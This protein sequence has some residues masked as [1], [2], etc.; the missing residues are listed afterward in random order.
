[1]DIPILSPDINEG[2]T[3]FSVSG[4]GIRYALAA[5]RSVG[6]PLID[7]IVEERNMYGLYTDIKDFITRL[8]GQ[9]NKKAMENFIKAGVFDS[10]GGTRQQY[11]C[12]YAQI[13]DGVQQEKKNNMTGQMTLFDLMEGGQKEEFA[14]TLPDVGEYP[15]ELLLSFEKDV[16]N[17]YVSG[18]PLQEY[19]ELWEKHVTAKTAEFLLQEETGE[20]AVRDGEVV[21]IGG[22][23]ADKT[24]KYTKKN[25]VM[26]YLRLE[27]LVGSVEV[28]IFEKTYEKYSSKLKEEN[29]VFIKGR[30]SAEEDKDAK[31][32]CDKVE[33]FDEVPKKL[34]LKFK[35]MEDYQKI[36][37][38]VEEILGASDGADQVIYYVEETKQ[39]KKLPPNRNVCAGKE[40]LE[41]LEEILGEENVKLR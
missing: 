35:D 23:I 22:I 37:P 6:R 15:K 19:R 31:V 7:A 27:D 21:T 17:A 1:M 30:V 5:I 4:G 11:M 34:W 29:K 12:V 18:H 10:F 33:E 16:L 38:K 2:E 32:I 28:L 8:T 41:A 14:V 3:G 13:M 26:A 25:K 36:S 40:L 9:V 20:A 39:L 24:I